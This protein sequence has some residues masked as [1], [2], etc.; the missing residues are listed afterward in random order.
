MHEKIPFADFI[1]VV[2]N[3]ALTS[4]SER[5]KW[6]FFI[7]FPSAQFTIFPRMGFI[8]LKF[9]RRKFDTLR[10][11]VLKPICTVKSTFTLGVEWM[12]DEKFSSKLRRSSTN[13]EKH[14]PCKHSFDI[15]IFLVNFLILLAAL[16]KKKTTG[17]SICFAIRSE[18]DKSTSQHVQEQI[19]SGW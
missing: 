19:S 5:V 13:S 11:F 15:Y 18:G 14:F 3:F 12:W 10:F 2:V 1:V 8:D 7:C 17:K 16:N 4:P 9:L 6:T